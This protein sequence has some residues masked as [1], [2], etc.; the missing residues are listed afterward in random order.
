[1]TE[2][3]RQWFTVQTYSGYENKVKANL[4]Q[5]IASMNMGNKIF[6]VLVP[7]EERVVLKDGKSRRVVHKLF[8]SYVFVE[9]IMDDQSWYVVRHT[10]GVTGFVGA[11]NHPL[12][13]TDDEINAILVKIGEKEAPAAPKV[14]IKCEV[15]DRVRVVSGSFAGVE[16]PVTEIMPNKGKV[17]F[18]GNV[19]GRETEIEVDYA[20]LEKL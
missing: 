11:G 3:K 6:R 12:P 16:G 5:R 10:P 19:F 13:V 8:P 15:G 18:M 14:E 9:M 1:M 2:N 7:T 17:K 20:E 4:D